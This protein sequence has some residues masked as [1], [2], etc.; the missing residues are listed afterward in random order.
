M[1][2]DFAKIDEIEGKY[3]FTKEEHVSSSAVGGTAIFDFADNRPAKRA[4]GYLFFSGGSTGRYVTGI[5]DTVEYLSPNNIVLTSKVN[6]EGVRVRLFK[7]IITV[8]NGLVTK[9]ITFDDL[10]VNNNADTIC[11]FYDERRKLKRTVQ[12]FKW[13]TIERDYFF[14]SS[15]N[16]QNI[17]GVKKSRDDGFVF[18]TSEETLGGYDD[19]PNPLKGLSLWE[20]LLY[21]TLSNNNFTAYTYKSGTSEEIRNFS[22]AYGGNGNVDFS[23]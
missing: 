6:I 3:L 9:K 14:D 12:F 20:D 18:Y 5:Y 7:R 1:K 8:E 23:K 4:G 19:R 11:Y 21:R 13:N 17:K 15:G 2:F 16:L 10:T 22:L